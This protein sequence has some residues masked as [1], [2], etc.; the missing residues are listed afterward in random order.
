MRVLREDSEEGFRHVCT[1]AQGARGR[2]VVALLG[3]SGPLVRGV[4]LQ[5]LGA[6]APHGPQAARVRLPGAAAAAA[7]GCGRAAT[8]ALA[9]Q[10]VDLPCKGLWRTCNALASGG[11]AGM[12]LG[13]GEAPATWATFTWA[14]G[15]EVG[16]EARA[17]SP[18]K[19]AHPAALAACGA[20]AGRL[21]AGFAR[22]SSEQTGEWASQCGGI[23]GL[24]SAR[25]ALGFG[26][27]SKP[28]LAGALPGVGASQASGAV[29]IVC[30]LEHVELAALAHL[31]GCAVLAACMLAPDPVAAVASR[32]LVRL[33]LV[34]VDAE[35]LVL[36]PSLLTCRVC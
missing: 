33:S 12:G 18:S 22:A 4:L 27:P 6:H 5:V 17:E 23:W 20:Q 29:L 21:P 2:D 10:T 8:A 16:A 9:G 19:S 11:R 3:G 15:R 34:M 1:H 7:T 25:R 30:R 14:S 24:H 26:S 31:S 28:A 36:N 13:T 32:W 35:L